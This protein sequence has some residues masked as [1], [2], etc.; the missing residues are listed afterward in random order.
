LEHLA[1]SYAEAGADSLSVLVDERHFSGHWDHLARVRSSCGLPLLAKGFFTDPVDLARARAHGADAVLLIARVL[2]VHERRRLVDVAHGL[3]M[4]VLLEVHEASDLA[5]S[6]GLDVDAIGVNHRDL[7]TL[8]LD[9]ER[10]RDLAPLLPVGPLR[11]AASGLSSRADVERM[12]A[13]GYDAVLV[14]SAL[15]QEDDPAAALR[16]LKGGAS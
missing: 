3:G 1:R 5:S 8:D 6:E 11:I 14:G 12:R 13:L 10:T 15:M 9:R 16:R 4:A 2:D 7:R